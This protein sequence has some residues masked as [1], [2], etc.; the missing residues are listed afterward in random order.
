MDYVNY[1]KDMF[2]SIPNFRKIAVLIFLFQNEKKLLGEN[3][4]SERDD[5]RLNLEFKN[6]L[7]EHREEY[8]EYEEYEEESAIERF[9]NK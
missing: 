4:S 6:I 7:I 3:G 1:F 9:L 5:N 8:L 2:Q